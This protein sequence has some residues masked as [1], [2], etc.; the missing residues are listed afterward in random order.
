MII[1][2]LLNSLKNSK[3][4]LKFRRW[5]IRSNLDVRRFYSM[6]SIHRSWRQIK[7]TRNRQTSY[8]RPGSGKHKSVVLQTGIIISKDAL[9][10]FKP[11]FVFAFFTCLF[12]IPTCLFILNSRLWIPIAIG[13]H[14]WSLF[15]SRKF[16]LAILTVQLLILEVSRV[17]I[18][19]SL[20]FN[21]KILMHIRR[22]PFEK[23]KFFKKF[24]AKR[25]SSWRRFLMDW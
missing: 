10:K 16:F 7:S 19:S 5:W 6:N 12:E 14:M 22:S 23:E 8:I 4:L 11:S 25:P 20:A 15:T 1:D 3:K 18:R 9:S 2:D 17:W 21:S 13:I 24:Q